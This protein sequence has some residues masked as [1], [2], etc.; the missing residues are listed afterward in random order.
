MLIAVDGWQFPVTQ[1]LVVPGSAQ[2]IAVTPQGNAFAVCVSG[3]DIWASRYNVSTGIW[4]A[5]T[6]LSPGGNPV[7]IPQVSVDTAGNAYVVWRQTGITPRI[8]A[9]VYTV[10]TNT[11]SAPTVISLIA[12]GTHVSPQVKAL[13]VG[14]AIAIFGKTNFPLPGIW[15]NIYS[16]GAWG[17]AAQTYAV[18]QPLISCQLATAP[19]NTAFILWN[20]TGGSLRAGRYSGGVWLAATTLNPVPNATS[21][22]HIAMDGVGN[23]IA[24]WQQSDGTNQRITAA[25]YT[26]ATDTWASYSYI[27][28]AGQN[29]L[30]PQI[31]MNNAGQAIAVWSR[32]NG[33]YDIIQAVFYNPNTASWQTIQDVSPTGQPNTNPVI[34]IDRNGNA[35]AVWVVNSNGIQASNYSVSTQTWG[36]LQTL[37]NAGTVP[38]ISMNVAGR[39][40]VDWTNGSIIQAL[41]YKPFPGFVGPYPACS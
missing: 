12:A 37:S 30:N 3:F 28:D 26:A 40:G 21:N 34:G 32:F 15:V 31:A 27:S 25:I 8:Y 24:V 10:A 35:I 39:A 29:A 11:W 4:Q 7:S 2:Q 36:S 16:A 38:Q 14:T 1:I 13:S 33:T 9:A 41:I 19:N 20:E 22:P 5:P 23:A 17:G 18:A 6:I